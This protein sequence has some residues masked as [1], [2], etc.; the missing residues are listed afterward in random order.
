MLLN[1]MIRDMR[2]MAWRLA[3]V[4][5]MLGLVSPQVTAQET[6]VAEQKSRIAEV[7]AKTKTAKSAT[8]YTDFVTECEALLDGE[9]TERNRAYVKSL[10]AWGY[11]RRGEKRLETATMFLDAGNMESGNK[12]LLAARKDFDDAT[13]ANPERMRAWF[14]Q[15]IANVHM[16]NYDAAVTSFTK[17]IDL[18]AQDPKIF[19]NR[20]EARYEAGQYGGAI[21]DYNRVLEEDSGDSQALTGRAHCYYAQANFEK[22]LQ[23]YDAVAA[24]TSDAPVALAN[25]ADIYQVMGKWEMAK[26]D[27]KSATT[28]ANCPSIVFEKAA[29][30]MA[31]CPEDSCRNPGIAMKLCEQMTDKESPRYFEIKAAALACKGEFKAAESMQQRALAASDERQEAMNSRLSLY[32]DG[33][34]YRQ[35]SNPDRLKLQ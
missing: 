1:T 6:S 3:L 19:F 26:A 20:A 22:A 5:T 12:V 24:L 18:K 9:L 23:D 7:Y 30:M 28:Q 34:E 17:A 31:T 27:F 33:K 21:E 2:A 25:R 4:V 35:A 16:Q 11:N 10:V 32:Q 29:W 15:G 8:D 13:K 14:Y